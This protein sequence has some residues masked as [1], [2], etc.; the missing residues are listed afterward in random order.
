[1]CVIIELHHP[2]KFKVYLLQF[3]MPFDYEFHAPFFSS[4][5]LVFPALN[6]WF[7]S[8]YFFFFLPPFDLLL[9]NSHFISQAKS[10]GYKT[11]AVFLRIYVVMPFLSS[12]TYSWRLWCFLSLWTESLTEKKPSKLIILW[13]FS[14]LIKVD[15]VGYFGYFSSV[16]TLDLELCNSM[17]LN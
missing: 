10:G 2:S 13:I 9:R 15:W 3:M 14:S 4:R 11:I 16:V 1:M 17:F 6:P 8:S 7:L 5:S 12:I